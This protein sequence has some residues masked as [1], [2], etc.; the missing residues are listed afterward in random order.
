MAPTDVG[1]SR[2]SVPTGKT[3]VAI[4]VFVSVA[5]YNVVELSFIIFATF[6]RRA[7]LYFWSFIVATWGIA[8]YGTGF[9][10]K[11]LRV[12]ENNSWVYGTLI[13]VGWPCM[14]TG[15]SCVLYSRLHIVMHNQ[16]RLRFV[17]GMIITNAIIC[18]I[19]IIVMIY[20]VNV[21][22]NQ[23]AFITPYSIYEK[24]QV[25]LFFVQET[26]ISG[27]YI[28]ETVAMLRARRRGGMEGTKGSVARRLMRHLIVVNVIV[29]LLDITILTLEYWGLYS[30]QTAYKALVYSVK[31]KIEFSILNRLVEMTQGT[32]STGSSARSRV[33]AAGVTGGVPLDNFDWAQQQWQRRRTTASYSA[34]LGNNVFVGSGGG[35]GAGAGAA[36]PKLKPA[37]E[38]VVMTTEVTVQ[39]NKVRSDDLDSDV[40]DLESLGDTS[41]VTVESEAAAAA[42]AGGKAR[43]SSSHSSE[44][45]SVETRD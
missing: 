11:A 10:T 32:S 9:L 7:G 34:R 14:V 20:G 28:K 39:R 3:L 33:E 15:Q 40:V 5:F 43:A 18:H 35:S 27:L 21:S 12:L 45:H 24:I 42:G 41:G 4:I 17:L 44:Q 31:L 38:S 2:D 23:G 25:S 8:P 16:N 30:I 29:I 1:I 13:S 6:K 36:D 19:P 22:N 37:G 26:I